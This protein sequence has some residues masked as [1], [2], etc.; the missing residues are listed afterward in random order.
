[1]YVNLKT[2]SGKTLRFDIDT[3]SFTA[4]NNDL[5]EFHFWQQ[6]LL[7]KR[8]VNEVKAVQARN[9]GIEVDRFP[10][11]KITAWNRCY[12]IVVNN[13]L[14]LESFD[15]SHIPQQKKYYLQGDVY[16]DGY[17]PF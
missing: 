6:I 13:K 10:P 8:E 4:I 17:A 2:K 12:S 7:E 3:S 14:Q 16:K 9:L 5:N 1:M 15:G 11:E